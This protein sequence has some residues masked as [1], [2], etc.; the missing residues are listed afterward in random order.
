MSSAWM[1]LCEWGPFLFGPTPPGAT[2]AGML[3]HSH[4]GECGRGSNGTLT[5]HFFDIFMEHSELV[6]SPLNGILC[7]STHKYMFRRWPQRNFILLFLEKLKCQDAFVECTLLQ[8]ASHYILLWFQLQKEY[9]KNSF[10][11][12]LH[13]W[14]H[15]DDRICCY[16]VRNIEYYLI[17]G[18]SNYEYSSYSRLERKLF[19]S[20]LEFAAMFGGWSFNPH[21]IS[22]WLTKL[23]FSG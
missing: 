8:N 19:Y 4:P 7:K 5:S 13:L 21:W 20:H 6:K 23:V 16:K 3:V 18:D 9:L 12:S 11:G 14:K 1:K 22:L 10:E 15:C 2:Q 17:V